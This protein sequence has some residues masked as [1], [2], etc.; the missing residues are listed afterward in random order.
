MVPQAL[1]RGNCAGCSPEDTN[2]MR[3]LIVHIQ[4]KFPKEWR[5]L[6]TTFMG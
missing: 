6:I 2:L 3:K 5:A 4:Q 1:I